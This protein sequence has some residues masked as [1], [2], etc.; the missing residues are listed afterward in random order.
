MKMIKKLFFSFLIV[1]ASQSFALACDCKPTSSIEKSFEKSNLVV[2]ARVLS[3]EFIQYAETLL[4]NWSDSLAKW[5]KEKGQLLDLSTIAP[6][7]IR[8]KVL[9]LKSYKNQTHLDTLTIFTP[10]RF[11]L[12]RNIPCDQG[13]PSNIFSKPYSTLDTCFFISSDIIKILIINESKI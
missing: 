4:P 8:I 10:R 11:F 3:K 13:I 7:V 9:V 12:C 5:A 1:V 2:H 6:N